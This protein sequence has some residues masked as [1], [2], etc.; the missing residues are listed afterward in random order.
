METRLINRASIATVVIVCAPLASLDVVVSQTSPVTALVRAHPL[1]AVLALV[2]SFILSA[3][4]ADLVMDAEW[5]TRATATV[6]SFAAMAA[7]VTALVI[8]LNALQR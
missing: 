2:L 1:V 6:M 4:F 7:Q 3:K 8:V 5:T